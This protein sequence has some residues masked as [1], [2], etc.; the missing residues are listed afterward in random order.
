VTTWKGRVDENYLRALQRGY[1]GRIID[2]G[3]G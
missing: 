2:M 3:R 1:A